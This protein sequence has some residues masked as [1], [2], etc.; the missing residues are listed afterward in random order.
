MKGQIVR[1]GLDDI[2]KEYFK[3]IIYSDKKYFM[4]HVHLDR[5]YLKK[6]RAVLISRMLPKEVLES[7]FRSK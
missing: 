4:D 2:F 3:R 1:N 6:N 7:L 5:D